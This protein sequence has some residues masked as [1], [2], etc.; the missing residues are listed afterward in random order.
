MQPKSGAQKGTPFLSLQVRDWSCTYATLSV[1]EKRMDD[2]KKDPETTM[3]EGQWWVKKKV[4]THND[5]RSNPFFLLLAGRIIR[6]FCMIFP[7]ICGSLQKAGQWQLKPTF[8]SQ[9]ENILLHSH[10][11]NFQDSLLH[12]MKH[13]LSEVSP[14]ISGFAAWQTVIQELRVSNCAA[15]TSENCGAKRHWFLWE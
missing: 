12:E 14:H 6:G 10:M 7:R 2:E 11:F 15:D 9:H 3:S 1:P 5:E 8:S 4:G 13:Q